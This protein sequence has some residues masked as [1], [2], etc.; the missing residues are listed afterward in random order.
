MEWSGECELR[1][2]NKPE[3]AHQK[4]LHTCD[5]EGGSSGAA[6]LDLDTLKIIGVHGGA[7]DDFNYGMFSSQITPQTKP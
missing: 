6:I 5:S 7:S 4:F 3:Q 2:Y 1:P